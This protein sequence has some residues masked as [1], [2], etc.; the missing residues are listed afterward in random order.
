M[1]FIPF[2]YR[3]AKVS[4]ERLHLGSR[5]L[6]SRVAPAKNGEEIW[7]EKNVLNPTNWI[8]WQQLRYQILRSTV[9][10]VVA[11]NA[12]YYYYYG[13]H[14]GMIRGLA[15]VGENLDKDKKIEFR[16]GIPLSYDRHRIL[17][18]R[19][20]RRVKSTCTSLVTYFL[21]CRFLPTSSL[22]PLFSA[23]PPRSR[24]PPRFLTRQSWCLTLTTA[25]AGRGG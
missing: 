13:Q 19:S 24:S 17:E 16:W 18:V 22:V 4:H 25:K 2:P 11:Y 21:V 8:F 23:Q 6:S 5:V 12:S 15:S 7:L 3:R 9:R 20:R 14:P 1:H 10:A